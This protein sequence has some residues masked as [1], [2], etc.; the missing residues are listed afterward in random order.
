MTNLKTGTKVICIDDHFE[1]V[2]TNPYKKSDITLPEKDKIY[3]I[4]KVVNTQYGVGVRLKEITN[5]E[6]Y[7]QNIRGYEE[8]IFSEERFKIKK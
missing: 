8:P 4:R 3:T 7:F 1:D 6:F 2:K 5:K